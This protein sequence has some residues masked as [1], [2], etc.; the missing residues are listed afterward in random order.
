VHGEHYRIREEAEWKPDE[1]LLAQA[2]VY[3]RSQIMAP[4]KTG[5]GPWAA[6][7]TAAE[8][9]GP[10][11]FGGWAEAGDGYACS[12]HGCGCGW[13]YEYLPGEPMGIRHPSPLIQLTANSEDQVAN[14]WRPLTAMIRLGPLADLL[15]VREDF[16]RILGGEGMTR[17]TG[18]T[19]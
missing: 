5:K 15:A 7:I 4:Q 14:V 1:P 19:R 2:F 13:E 3:R 12:E 10:V 6:G 18:S 16:I 8:A 9:V 17:A 11:V